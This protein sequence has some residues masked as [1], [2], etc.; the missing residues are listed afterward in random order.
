MRTP[1]GESKTGFST[2]ANCSYSDYEIHR[3]ARESLRNAFRHAQAGHIETEITYGESLRL[4]FRDD[5]KGMDPSVVEH[6]GRS[7]HWGLPGIHERAKQIGAELTVWSELGAGTEVELS[8]PGSIAYE[9]S[10]TRPRFRLFRK[11]AEQ[12]HEHRS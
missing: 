7:G 2:R 12:D 11:R 8:I 3:I 9:A 1:R 6:G 4:R 5:G 10:P